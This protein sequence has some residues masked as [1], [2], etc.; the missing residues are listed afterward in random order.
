MSSNNRFSRFAAVLALACGLV[1]LALAQTVAVAPK[2]EYAQIDVRLTNE[3]IEALSR[4]SAV[5]RRKTV[6]NI[7]THPDR[8]EPPALYALADALFRDGKKDEGAFWFYAGQLRARFDAN[9]CADVSAR[10]SVHA[11]T[12][13]YGP[14]VNQYAFQDIPK[15]EALIPKVIEWDRNTPHNYD[16]RWINLHG[17]N[18]MMV[19][20]GEKKTPGALSLPKEQWDSIAEKTRADYL[21]GFKEAM[22]NLRNKK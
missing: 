22:A 21:R 13:S 2:G 18:A 20:L 14:L 4:G 5:E 19:G 6:A 10:Q 15:L 16:H 12:Y 1:P 17:M 8:Y 9:R 11:L 7:Q 3:A